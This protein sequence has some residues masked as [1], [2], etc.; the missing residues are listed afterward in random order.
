MGI[1]KVK[2]EPA[3]LPRGFD[4][5]PELR[6]KLHFWRHVLERS[7]CPDTAY[8]LTPAPS[9]AKSVSAGQ[10]AVT[11][12]L[13]INRLPDLTRLQPRIAL[14]QVRYA[15]TGE[16]AIDYHGWIEIG[17]V[18]DPV[19]VDLTADQA[20]RCDEN[21]VLL[22]SSETSTISLIY[23]PTK[24]LCRDKARNQE[25]W[26][27]YIRLSHLLSMTVQDKPLPGIQT[28]LDLTEISN[29]DVR[30]YLLQKLDIAES[31]DERLILTA[32]L[33][34]ADRYSFT[35]TRTFPRPDHP[36]ENKRRSPLYT[37]TAI[38][39][40]LRTTLEIEQRVV[41]DIIS[42]YP[43]DESLLKANVQ[44]LEAILRPAGMAAQKAKTI[45]NAMDYLK[46]HHN[47]SWSFFLSEP[48]DVAREELLRIPGLGPKSVD[49]LL[50]VG[51]GRPSIAVDVNV[52]RAVSRLSGAS[53]AEKPDYSDRSQVAAIKKLL[54]KVVQSDSMLAQVLHTLFLLHGKNICKSKC[55]HSKSPLQ[56]ICAHCNKCYSASPWQKGLF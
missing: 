38:V 46:R 16:I 53:W 21:V 40:S 3:A 39:T 55:S 8:P 45:R 31:F 50:T 20:A 13:L 49:C 41:L 37:L 52:F 48:L 22:K 47:N 27:R 4:P 26:D 36:D 19:I 5:L 54:D 44:D 43:D 24:Y 9:F 12:I 7:W 17:N 11:S 35:D 29:D 15:D 34:C 28:H 51:L 18:S 32:A 25:V 2:L 56:D 14:G 10:C 6:S 23:F 30:K 1:A 33:R 42:R